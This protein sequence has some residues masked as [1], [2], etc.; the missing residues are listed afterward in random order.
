MET[1]NV[2]Q[3]AYELECIVKTIKQSAWG[4][5]DPQAKEIHNRILAILPDVERC[6]REVN[7]LDMQ[8][9]LFFVSAIRALVRESESYELIDREIS[10]KMKEARH[11]ID[12]GKYGCGE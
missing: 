9:R 12:L 5:T 6:A 1:Q 4:M 11:G 2:F 7:A 8:T 10:Q 3:V